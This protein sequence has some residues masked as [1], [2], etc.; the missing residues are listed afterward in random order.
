MDAL[1]LVLLLSSSFHKASNQC[2]CASDADSNTSSLLR[3]PQLETNFRV[4]SIF[5]KSRSLLQ[6]LARRA[7]A[8]I[9]HHDCSYFFSFSPPP[10]PFPLVAST[11]YRAKLT[12]SYLAAALLTSLR[13]RAFSLSTVARCRCVCFGLIPSGSGS[14]I[15][16][17]TRSLTYSDSE[18]TARSP[19]SIFA[20]ALCRATEWMRDAVGG[21]KGAHGI[22]KKEE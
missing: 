20:A 6:H 3:F 4:S 14:E 8:G 18:M 15:A 13:A 22:G 19:L 11:R 17:E 7:C 21:R 12:D 10:L 1:E 9:P 16:E 5:D 2:V